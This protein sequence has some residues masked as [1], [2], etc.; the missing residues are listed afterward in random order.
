VADQK[1][2]F[3]VWA[4]VL[5]DD[6][7]VNLRMEDI[8]RWTILGALMCQYGTNGKLLIKPPSKLILNLFHVDTISDLQMVLK[9]LPNVH[10]D[11]PINDNGDFVVTIKNWRKYQVDSTVAQ[12]VSSLRRKKRQEETRE[13]NG[14]FSSTSKPLAGPYGG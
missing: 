10:F 8:G 7:F 12:R 4:T 11:P 2:W 9:V 1:K 6:S 5:I 3:K 13:D 14:D